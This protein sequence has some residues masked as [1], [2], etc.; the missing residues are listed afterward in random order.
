MLKSRW[1][2]H[3]FFIELKTLQTYG[4]SS[5]HCHQSMSYFQYIVKRQR[6]TGH[7]YTEIGWS[8]NL[9]V[10]AEWVNRLITWSHNPKN[11]APYTD[12]TYTTIQ[13][14]CQLG[15]TGMHHLNWSSKLPC[16]SLCRC[17]RKDLSRKR[18]ILTCSLI[19][20]AKFLKNT[21]FSRYTNHTI[22][23][24]THNIVTVNTW[25]CTDVFMITRR[26]VEKLL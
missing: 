26:Q 6:Y 22:W 11:R 20:E 25:T 16:L 23:L 1:V 8:Y 19:M 15:Q 14:L 13:N 24:H 17:I 18:I 3:Y 10:C 7:W 9:S 2:L 21:A 12:G 4:S 5:H